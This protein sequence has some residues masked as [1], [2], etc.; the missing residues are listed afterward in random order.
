MTRGQ[1]RSVLCRHALGPTRLVFLNYGSDPIV[2]FTTAVG[3]HPPAWLDK[4]RAPDVPPELR[5]YPIVTMFQLALDSA[6]SLDVPRHGHNCVAEDYIGAW[7]EGPSA[8]GLVRGPAAELRPSSPSA[9]Q[10]SDLGLSR[11]DQ[12]GGWQDRRAG[13]GSGPRGPADAGP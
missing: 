9:G 6:I 5:W 1:G 10:L 8:R 11:P 2:A 7:A 3:V 13:S 12:G 4:P